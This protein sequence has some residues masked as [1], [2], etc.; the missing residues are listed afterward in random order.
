MSASLLVE[1]GKVGK[2]LMARNEFLTIFAE[3]GIAPNRIDGLSGQRS[4]GPTN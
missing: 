2:W 4:A 1:A 3:I